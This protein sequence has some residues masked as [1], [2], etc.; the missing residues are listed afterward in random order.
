M[1]PSV[2]TSTLMS[3]PSVSVTWARVVSQQASA[4]SS[5]ATFLAR[6]L[7]PYGPVPVSTNVDDHAHR[8]A[9]D[10]AVF[11]VTLCAGREIDQD[12]YRFA[13]ERAAESFFGDK[14]AHR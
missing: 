3:L 9:A 5:V 13:T 1:R 11:D 12:R 2:A 8:L 10:L 14:F 6:T 4:A 7:H